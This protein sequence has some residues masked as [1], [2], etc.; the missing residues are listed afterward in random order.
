MNETVSSMAS[1]CKF[2]RV[3]FMKC[4]KR[5]C[6]AEWEDRM[7]QEN[8]KALEDY[9]PNFLRQIQSM[10]TDMTREDDE[11]V[12]LD[13][14]RDGNSILLMERKGKIYRMNSAFRPVQEAERWAAQFNLDHLENV[15]VLFGLGNGIFTKSLIKKMNKDDELII[16]EPSSQIFRMVLEQ[17]DISSVLSDSRVHTIVEGING[18]DFYFTLEERLNWKNVDALC[19]CEHPEYKKLYPEHYQAFEAQIDECRELVHVMKHTEAHFAHQSIINCFFNMRYLSKANILGDFV[20]KFPEGF[21]AIIVSAGPSLDKNIEELRRAE[22]KAFIFAVDSAV[23]ELLDRGISFDAMITVDAG[24]SPAHLRREECKDIPLFCVLMSRT[25]ILLTHRGKKIFIVGGAC[26][27]DF[28]EE[29]GH[30]FFPINI[31]GSVS[32][33]AFSVCEK[34][35]FQRIVL[36]GQ[37]LAYDGEVTHAGGKTKNIVNENIGRRLV[38]GWYGDRVKSRYDWIIYRNWFESAIQQLPDVEVID[39]TEGGALIHG[40]KTMR[41]SE[42]ID[43]YCIQ[44]FSMLELLD[45]EPPTFDAKTFEGMREK[46]V[47]LE[48]EMGNIKRN[49]EEAVIICDQVINLVKQCGADISLNKQVKRL[50]ALNRLIVSQP[51]YGFLDYYVTEAAVEDLKDINQMTGSKEQDM[52]DAYMS[53]RALYHSMIQAVKDLSG[54]G[55]KESM[56]MIKQCLEEQILICEKAVELIEKNQYNKLAKEETDAQLKEIAKKIVEPGIF[57]MLRSGVNDVIC[58]LPKSGNED[59][60]VMNGWIADN[61]LCIEEADK[62]IK[63]GFVHRCLQRV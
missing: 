39:A 17:E 1:H 62:F 54:E 11:R 8:E 4:G 56:K 9:Q 30:P 20:G 43:T 2:D 23:K 12:E 16:Y 7:L 52:L 29:K 36:I 61:K 3:K 38:D 33:A 10:S 22:G 47:H 57:W 18:T 25:H 13:Q 5:L 63:S 42:V 28:Y 34:M 32:T 14:A 31:G 21:P 58:K 41:L 59:L 26:V 24:K 55:M 19:V 49:S 46:F 45:R 35:G 15:V 37:D 51:V 53:A 44:S 50:E 60:D 6:K 48:K 40:S 27:D